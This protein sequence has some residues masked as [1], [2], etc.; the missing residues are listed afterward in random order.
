VVKDHAATEDILQEA[1]LKIILK[2][3]QL[4]SRENIRAWIKVVVRNTMY[5]Y[6]SMPVWNEKNQRRYEKLAEIRRTLVGGN[7]HHPAGKK[8]REISKERNLIGKQKTN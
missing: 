7:I 8:A 1:F 3:H 4:E 5:N 2:I 6:L